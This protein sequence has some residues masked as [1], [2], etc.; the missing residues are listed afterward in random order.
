[1]LL[2]DCAHQALPEVEVEDTVHV[3]ARHGDVLVNYSLNQFQAPNE[4]C[5]QFNALRGSVRIEIHRQRWG[6]FLDGAQDWV[7]HDVPVADRD[8]HFV[9]QAE[10]FLDQLEG[11][12]ARLCSLEQALQSL[13]FN[14]AALASA[15]ADRR[16]HC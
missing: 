9:A 1:S 2:C 13:R 3:S 5:L 6:V 16:I 12:P 14:L 8:A 11:A 7:W 15:E 4:A 10:A